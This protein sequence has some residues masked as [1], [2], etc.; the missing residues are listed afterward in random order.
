MTIS[1]IKKMNF[2]ERVQ[3]MEL[4]WD[5]LLKDDY[6][7]ESPTWHDDVLRERMEKIDNNEAKFISLVQINVK[8]T[9][10]T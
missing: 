6:G 9:N 1:E 4:L 3:A 10:E 2:I 5:S 7:I 8:Y